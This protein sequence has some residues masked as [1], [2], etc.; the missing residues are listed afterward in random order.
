MCRPNTIGLK[1]FTLIELI[2]VIVILGVLSAVAVPRFFDRGTFDNAFNQ[3]QV[4]AALAEARAHAV[5][6]QCYTAAH[7]VSNT[8]ALR[9]NSTDCATFPMTLTATFS[10]SADLTETGVIPDVVLVFTPMGEARLLGNAA[11]LGTGFSLGNLADFS[12]TSGTYTLSHASGN[13]ILIDDQT[14]YVR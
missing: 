10:A 5:H 2:L 7:F 8:L 13:D 12:G 14:G 1:G 3:R 9:T 11:L 6:A 4:R